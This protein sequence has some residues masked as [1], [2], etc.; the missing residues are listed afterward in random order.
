VAEVNVK[1]LHGL[2]IGGTTHHDVVLA[3]PTVADLLEC[4]QE[5][6]RAV[7]T[8]AGPALVSSPTIMGALMLCRQIKSIGGTAVPFNIELLKKLHPEDLLLLQM[9]AD[10][11][12]TASAKALEALI[13]LGRSDGDSAGT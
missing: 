1:L 12:A 7:L 6:E 13:N 5:S 3:E 11:M 2:T 8:A 10:K 9:E 4:G